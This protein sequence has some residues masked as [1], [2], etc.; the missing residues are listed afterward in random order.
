MK[1]NFKDC[2]AFYK[3]SE[4]IIGNSLIERK[5]SL[6]NGIPASCYI[7]NKKTGYKFEAKEA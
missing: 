4:L 3:D 1:F 2:Y 7:L 6:E 5:I